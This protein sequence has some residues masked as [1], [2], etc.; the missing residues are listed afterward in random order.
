[1]QSGMNKVRQGLQNLAGS[2]G[3]GQG[4]GSGQ[5]SGQ[6]GQ[7]GQQGQGN[8]QGGQTGGNG[9]LDL[10]VLNG[11][12]YRGTTI[13]GL[14]NDNSQDLITD[15]KSEN[16]SQERAQQIAD[17]VLRR[18]VVN[19]K[20]RGQS[21]GGETGSFL[22]RYVEEVLAPKVNWKKVL[23]RKLTALAEKENSFSSPD[24]RFIS[25]DR[26]LPG[27]RDAEPGA[28]EGVK[29]CIDTS[30]SISDEDLGIALAQI[31]QLLKIYKAK[32]ELLYWDT[33][34]HCGYDFDNTSFKDIIK[35]KPLGGGGTDANCIFKYFNQCKEYKSGRKQTPSVVIVFTD[36]YFGDVERKYA[37]K[38]KDTIWVICGDTEREKFEPPFGVVAELKNGN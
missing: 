13:Q 10:S 19:H 8:G 12:S 7:N 35:K 37:K 5:G 36:G 15:S 23:K 38:Y 25:R 21:F 32:A 17:S 2:Q 27:P 31:K 34:V 22:E 26:I 16:L 24:K 4:Q 14:S 18:A 11:K 33:Q 9:P 3:Q 30:G 1:M 28:L 6:G 20:M 29:I